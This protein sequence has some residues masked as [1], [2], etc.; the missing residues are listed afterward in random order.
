ML[1]PVD[2]SGISLIGSC[3]LVCVR[4]GVKVMKGAKSTG[5]YEGRGITMGE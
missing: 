2:N 1:S 3:L 4:L 5:D